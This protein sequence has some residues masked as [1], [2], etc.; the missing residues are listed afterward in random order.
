MPA[1]FK[2]IKVKAKTGRGEG[3]AGM[4]EEFLKETMPGAIEAF[5][6]CSE[7][8]K[9]EVVD[10]LN[11]EKDGLGDAFARGKD[12]FETECLD[13]NEDDHLSFFTKLKALGF[14]ITLPGE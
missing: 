2:K 5:G 12:D 7:A 9:Q 8:E 11:A 14:D 4:M 3:C 10:G 1:I 13:I 6:G